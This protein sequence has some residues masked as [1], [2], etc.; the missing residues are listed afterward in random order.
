MSQLYA[1]A[2]QRAQVAKV[3]YETQLMQNSAVS[4]ISVDA[5]ED[6]PGQPAVVI[7]VK[8][9]PQTPL[10]HQVGGVRTKVVFD[11][12]AAPITLSKSA[13]ADAL[14]VK[15]QHSADLRSNPKIFG[16]GV[17]ASKD[18]PGEAAI[19]IYVDRSSTISVPAEID[20][21]RTQVVR[22]DPFRAS[23]WRKEAER[24]TGCIRQ[25]ISTQLKL[26]GWH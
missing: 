22:T 12:L 26:P 7:H 11:Q 24:P 1:N 16:V 8:A 25:G 4:A 17:S 9:A 2:L 14:K 10:P 6:D 13:I 21:L 23:G 18:S 19:V 5:S 15:N 3:R 20:G